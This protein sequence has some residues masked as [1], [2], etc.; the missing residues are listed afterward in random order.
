MTYTNPL[1]IFSEAQLD[2]LTDKH[3]KSLKKEILLHF[4]LSDK[5]TIDRNG[6]QYDKNQILEIFDDLQQNLEV[7]LKIFNNKALLAF[8][9]NADLDFFKNKQAID[10]V[11]RDYLF[12]DR[13][14]KHVAEQINLVSASLVNKLTA[15]SPEALESIL[16]YS[17][18]MSSNIKDKAY[19][20]AYLGLKTHVDNLRKKYPHPFIASSGLIIHPDLYELIDPV[21][22]DCFKHLP[23]AFQDIGYTYGVWCHNEIVN[24]AFERETM[25]FLYERNDLSVIVKAMEIGCNVTK[26]EAFRENTQEIKNYLADQD[27]KPKPQQAKFQSQSQ[28]KSQS[29]TQ[30]S[31][32]SQSQSPPTSRQKTPRYRQGNSKSS[33]AGTGK[34]LITAILVI[35]GILRLLLG[36]AQC[37]KNDSYTRNNGYGQQQDYQKEVQD[38]IKKQTRASRLQNQT[39]LLRYIGDDKSMWNSKLLRTEE[40]NNVIELDYE[41]DVF[42]TNYQ[43]FSFL[44]PDKIKEKYFGESKDY[45]VKFSNKDFPGRSF[46][47]RFRCNVNSMDRKNSVTLDKKSSNDGNK[48]SFTV[49]RLL[50]RKKLKGTITRYGTVDNIFTELVKVPFEIADDLETEPIVEEV[51]PNKIPSFSEEKFDR[52]DDYSISN[53]KDQ[54][55]KN[56][57][58]NNFNQVAHKVLKQG[59]YYSI[60]T[61]ASYYPRSQG[62]QLLEPKTESVT[63]LK[64]NLHLEY[65]SSED[66]VATLSMYGNNFYI[67]YFVSGETKRIIG[68]NMATPSGMGD[69][70]EVIEVFFE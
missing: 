59:N 4:Q 9:E 2:K 46:S 52:W 41:V 10:A 50:K 47:Y 64:G 54:H 55:Y 15:K 57:I 36:I 26:S 68:M 29:Q 63:E 34:T 66:E 61:M 3:L 65:V 56:I 33:A 23:G 20:K 7:H 69:V 21:F 30:A 25:Y 48:L 17:S 35:V 12:R 70:V 27:L 44:I 51:N 42:P 28:S 39:K 60:Q 11:Q 18:K 6:K 5:A 1:G 53:I 22:Y 40:V 14:D 8:L 37:N 32:K 43:D 58:L 49:K 38:L 16:N 24:K 62:D 45:V 67:R 13:I 31:S 19:N